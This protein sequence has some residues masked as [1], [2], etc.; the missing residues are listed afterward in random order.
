MRTRY[1]LASALLLL[2]AS[3]AHAQQSDVT[4]AANAFS[5]AQHA[6]LSGDHVRAA[7]LYELADRIAPT[8]DALRAATRARF[9]AGQLSSAASSAEELYRRYPEDAESKKLAD[10]VLLKAQTSLAR[11]AVT[12]GS[13]CKLTVNGLAAS[14]ESR[15]GHIV[16]VH[17]GPHTLV[18]SFEDGSSRTERIEGAAG[19]RREVDLK[20]QAGSEAEAAAEPPPEPEPA[21]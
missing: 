9:A 3:R 20:P 8:P 14:T 12:C 16:Y 13:P 4:A 6:E 7:D 17:P 1:L 5:Q 10:E 11:V 18:A 19:D 15:A 21:T 2:L